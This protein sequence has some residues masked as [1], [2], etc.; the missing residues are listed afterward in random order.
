MSTYFSIDQYGHDQ[1]Y[2]P[3]DPGPPKAFNFSED[4]SLAQIA[5]AWLDQGC[6]KV[7][8]HARVFM[9]RISRRESNPKK[10]LSQ[11]FCRIMELMLNFRLL[12][13]EIWPNENI[14]FSSDL[15]RAGAPLDRFCKLDHHISNH[16]NPFMSVKLWLFLLYTTSRQPE[17]EEF[18][19]ITGGALYT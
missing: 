19:S 2:W 12:H 16:I 3:S 18:L 5:I 15:R 14:S 1:F 8:H 11:K 4:G 6:L 9:L 17:I 10:E 13:L 7:F